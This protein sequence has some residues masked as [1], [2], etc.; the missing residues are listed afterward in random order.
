MRVPVMSMAVFG[1][2]LTA[3]VWIVATDHSA[4]GWKVG[5]IAELEL[6]HGTR[7]VARQVSGRAH[8]EIHMILFDEAQCRLEVARNATRTGAKAIGAIASA[9]GALAACNGGYFHA[10]GDF[11]PTGLEIAKGVLTGA[12]EPPAPYGGALVVKDGVGALVWDHE[13]NLTPGITDYVHCNPFLVNDGKPWM[14]LRP[15]LQD[16]R[17]TRTFI[18]TDGKGRWAIGRCSSIGLVELADL[19][20]V[21]DVI[22]GL[23]VERALN[24]DGGPSSS[25]WWRDRQGKVHEQTS[26]VIVRNHVLVVPRS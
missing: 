3:G 22:P 16:V 21:P 12:V 2:A 8:V 1:L 10:G 26:G 6:D 24:L 11:A 15:E 4:S 7:K 9:A 19:L 14:P 20:L 25:L 17:A 23:K 5:P 13:F 18:A